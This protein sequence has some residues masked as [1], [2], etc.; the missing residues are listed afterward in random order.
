MQHLN[1]AATG[2][3]GFTTPLAAATLSLDPNLDLELRV[4][5]MVIGIVVGILSLI[6]LV[7]D[8]VSDRKE[9]Q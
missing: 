7:C 9:K 8:F 4:A 3:I 5:S 2:V 6:K 1:T